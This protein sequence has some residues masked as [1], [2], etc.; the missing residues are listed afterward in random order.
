MKYYLKLEGDQY[1]EGVEFSNV[2]EMR[3]TGVYR[4]ENVQQNIVGDYLIDR[5]GREKLQITAKLN[6]L[7]T[8]EMY[9]LRQARER[10]ENEFTFDRG[11]VR[12]TKKFRI[13]PFEEPSPIYYN[14]VPNFEGGYNYSVVYPTLT[15]T[16]EEM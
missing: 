13:N 12:T 2:S 3:I 11:G 4:K 16:L 1:T 14:P 6:L 8:T 7:S 5:V 15:I 10:I 9:S